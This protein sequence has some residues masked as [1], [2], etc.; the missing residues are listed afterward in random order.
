[1]LTCIQLRST[2]LGQGLISPAALLFNCFIK[3]IMSILIR[4]QINTNSHNDHYESIVEIQSN[5]EK[6]YDTLR[7]YNSVPLESTVMVQ[8]KDGGPWIHGRIVEKED[9]NTQGFSIHNLHHKEM[10]TD[11]REPQTCGGDTNQIR[12]ISQGS[13]FLGQKN[14]H[15]RGHNKEV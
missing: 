5:T 3:G 13:A 9:K 6:S 15:V 1:M 7:N 10:M 14:G 12:A 8:R 11:N 2:P 4:Q